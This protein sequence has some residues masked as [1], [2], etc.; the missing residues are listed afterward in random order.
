LNIGHLAVLFLMRTIIAIP[1]IVLLTRI[2][3]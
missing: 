2:I 1:V 3:F